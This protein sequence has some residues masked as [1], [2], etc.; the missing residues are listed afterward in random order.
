MNLKRLTLIA[1]RELED[2]LTAIL[3]E[4][5]PTLPGFTTVAVAGHGESFT[6]ASTRERVHGRIDRLMLWL[7]LPTESAK[8][9]LAQ[10]ER[11]LPQSRIIWWLEAVEARGRLA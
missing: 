7:V 1:P 11:L 9:V 10:I 6:Y 5:E 4:M 2:A 8:H 3:L